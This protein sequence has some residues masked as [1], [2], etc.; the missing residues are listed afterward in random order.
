MQWPHSLTLPPRLL[1][2]ERT[3]H[4]PPH[5]ECTEKPCTRCSCPSTS[6]ACSAMLP[7]APGRRGPTH[8]APEGRG[9]AARP[10]ERQAEEHVTPAMSSLRIR[11]T[12]SQILYSC[13]PAFRVGSTS[14]DAHKAAWAVQCGGDLRGRSPLRS[15]GCFERCIGWREKPA[16]KPGD[17]LQHNQAQR[18]CILRPLSCPVSCSLFALH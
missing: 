14:P 6:V 7:A 16:E 13:V 9:D 8:A 15:E 17:R 11:L 12:D 3:A 4:P 2:A 5:A 18:I 10:T 1:P